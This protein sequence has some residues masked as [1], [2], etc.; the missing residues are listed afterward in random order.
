[1]SKNNIGVNQKKTAWEINILKEININK[2]NI[3][4]SHPTNE[5]NK[6]HYTTLEIQILAWDRQNKVAG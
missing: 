5:N 1:M 6:N 2:T 4:I 3:H